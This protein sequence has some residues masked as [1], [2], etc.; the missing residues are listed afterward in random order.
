MV[1]FIMHNPQDVQE[2]QMNSQNVWNMK[3]QPPEVFKLLVQLTGLSLGQGGH[4]AVCLF[5]NKIT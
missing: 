3:Q 5:V 4:V 2:N 1:K